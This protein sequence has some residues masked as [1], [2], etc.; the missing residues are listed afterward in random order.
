MR[1][2]IAGLLAVLATACSEQREPR[3]AESC[4]RTAT[5]QVT[6]SGQAPDTVTARADGPTCAQAV[7]T[8]TIRNA[9]GDPLW[10]FASTHHDMI[11]GGYSTDPAAVSPEEVD[12]FLASWVDVTVNSSADLPAWPEGVESLSAAVEGISYFTELDREAYEML[13][14]RNL[15]QLCFAASVSSSQCLI[16]DPL[17]NAPLMIAAYGS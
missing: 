14:T 6:W 5:R 4:A 10:A 15:P 11:V 17:S 7:V 8:F 1:V 13:R 16:M 9:D 2:L 3:T 12:R